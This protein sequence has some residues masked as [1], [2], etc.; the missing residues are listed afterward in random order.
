[1]LSLIK[2]HV[3]YKSLHIRERYQTYKQELVSEDTLEYVL[4]QKEVSELELPLK[5]WNTA[6]ESEDLVN[7][8]ST[9]SERQQQIVWLLFVEEI[10][11][12]EIN[13]YKS[14]QKMERRKESL[15]YK[16]IR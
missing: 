8:V 15:F 14:R 11:V 10:P 5:Q 13:W 12:T 1:M 6:L 7:A 4:N 3:K 2:I 9:L 16:G